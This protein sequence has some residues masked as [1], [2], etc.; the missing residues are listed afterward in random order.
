LGVLFV[1]KIVGYTLIVVGIADFGLSYMGVNLTYFLPAGISKFTPFVFG[2]L[3]AL[4]L[5]GQP[6]DKD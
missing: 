6:K 3:G 2:G 1:G 4:I 5:N